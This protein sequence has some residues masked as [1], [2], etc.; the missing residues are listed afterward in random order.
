MAIAAGALISELKPGRNRSS[1][2][3]SEIAAKIAAVEYNNGMAP[4]GQSRPSSREHG[5]DAST[6]RWT[7]RWLHTA[8]PFRIESVRE[9]SSPDPY[10]GRNRLCEKAFI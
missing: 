3:G 10:H 6:D 5:Y 8:V 7:D 4:V 9:L 2:L 1:N